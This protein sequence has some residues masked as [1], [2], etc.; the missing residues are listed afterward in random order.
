MPTFGYGNE[1]TMACSVAD[2]ET[3][4]KWFHDM[5]GFD[6]IYRIAEMGWAEMTTSL[7]NVTL[8][9]GQNEIVHPAGGATPV[10]SVT[11]IDT[12]RQELE[13]KGV[14]FDGDTQVVPEMVKLATFYDPDGNTFMLSESLSD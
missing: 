3:S 12:A 1:I 5:L 4:I 7:P 11:D 8:G 14:A 9:L 2:L 13:N 6:E 10:F